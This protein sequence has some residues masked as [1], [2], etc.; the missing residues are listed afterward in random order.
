MNASLLTADRKTHLKIMLV[1]CL[2]SLGMF[3]FAASHAVRHGSRTESA[4]PGERF[5]AR[6]AAYRAAPYGTSADGK[7]I[8][9]SLHAN[10]M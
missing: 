2:C 4:A 9:A 7:L 8:V 1:A 10:S 5:S 3:V 6:S